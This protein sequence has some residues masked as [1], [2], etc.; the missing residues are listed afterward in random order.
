M[1]MSNKNHQNK[2]KKNKETEKE[3]SVCHYFLT[4][5]QSN[6]KQLH[7]PMQN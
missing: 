4:T 1:Q 5:Y 6:G 2:R 7:F 3:I